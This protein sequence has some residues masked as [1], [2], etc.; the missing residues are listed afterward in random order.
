M[1]LL[2]ADTHLTVRANGDTWSLKK[3]GT[4]GPTLAAG[5]RLKTALAE[6]LG[7]G[8]LRREELHRPFVQPLTIA[9]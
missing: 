1:K 3:R 8:A 2:P 4:D 6:G 9:A 5:L 7:R